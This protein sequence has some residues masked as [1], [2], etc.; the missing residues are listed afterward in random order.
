MLVPD[1]R[2]ARQAHVARQHAQ[3]H[4]AT[5]RETAVARPQR[6]ARAVDVDARELPL[7]V[8]LGDHAVE[9]D[10]GLLAER[11][12]QV[13]PRQHLAQ[14]PGG[15]DAARFHHHQVV[16][17][18]RHFVDGVADV[19]DRQRQLVVQAVEVGQ[20][21]GLAAR[22]ER[23]QRFVEQQQARVGAERARDRDALAF[24]AR[25]R[26]R[27]PRHQRADAQQLD[28]A[29]ERDAAL[30][31]RDAAQAVF[32]VAA[33]VEVREQRRVLDH[34]AD[35]AAMRRHPGAGGVVLPDFGAEGEAALR[36][37]QPGDGAQHGGLAAARRAEQRRDA[38]RRQLERDVEREVAAREAELGLDHRGGPADSRGARLTT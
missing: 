27:A 20:H 12:R 38:A 31:G 26:G 5:Q 8:A 37:L 9:H 14:R 18:A 21:L 15:E 13:E 1:L 23:R 17:Q 10:A 34:V 33:H 16:G 11:Q 3:P 22:V 32:E 24:A 2:R 30:A 6:G 28:D 19:D 35:G 4:A 7:R 25:E 36:T 29:V